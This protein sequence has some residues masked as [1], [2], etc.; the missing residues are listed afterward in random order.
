MHYIQ[1]QCPA[2][3][4]L[5]LPYGKSTNPESHIKAHFGKAKEQLCHAK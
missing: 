4:A 1:K 3:R 2:T 5:S